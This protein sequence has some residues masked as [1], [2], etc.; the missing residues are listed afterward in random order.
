MKRPPPGTAPK[1]GATR[2]PGGY[3]DDF[4]A[5]PPDLMSQ[6]YQQQHRTPGIYKEC[7]VVCCCDVCLFVTFPLWCL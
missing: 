1:P 6:A 5:P 3:G 4:P 2:G 7:P